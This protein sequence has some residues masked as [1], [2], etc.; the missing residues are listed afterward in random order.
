LPV[1]KAEGDVDGSAGSAKGTI[2]MDFMGSLFEGDFVL[3]DKSLYF[4]GPTGDDWQKV[5]A[6]LVTSVY[7][8]GAI[9]DPDRGIAKVLGSV[10]DPHTEGSED[11]DGVSTYRVTGRVGVDVVKDLVPG[12]DSDVNVTF[13]LAQD[14]GHQPVKASVKVTD[15]ATV[16]VTLSDIGKQVSITAPQ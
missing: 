14:G 8:P 2:S 11:V 3:V 4:K 6:S 9:L 1:H 7:D 10:Q 16:D 15:D 5:P 13:W 12:V